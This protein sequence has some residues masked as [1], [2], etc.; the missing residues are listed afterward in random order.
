MA[1]SLDNLPND[2]EELKRLVVEQS[3]QLHH[4]ADQLK[5]QNQLI[6]GLKKELYGRKSEKL[7]EEEKIQVRLFNEVEDGATKEDDVT[8]AKVAS[9]KRRKRGRKPISPDFPRTEVIHDIS[10]E[11]KI[12]A[13][14]HELS[15]IGE[16][17]SE[18]IDIIPMDI[19]VL[20]H[21]RPKYACK[22]C[23]GTATEGIE[24]TV[25]I[26]KIPEQML[27]KS[28]SSPGLLAH[29]LT[30]KFCDALPFYRQEKIFKRFGLELPRSTM[31]NMAIG[32]YERLDRYLDQMFKELLSGPVLFIDETPVQVLKEPGKKNTSKSYM[33]VLR[34][35]DPKKPVVWY[36]Y[37]PTRSAAFLLNLLKGYQGAV[38]TDGYESYSKVLAEL[39][40]PHAGCWVHARRKFKNAFDQTKKAAGE[41]K[42]T[43][44]DAAHALAV[45]S[46]LY[47]LD[48]VISWVKNT[49]KKKARRQN[50]I[51]PLLTEFFD[52]LQQQAAT[53]TPRSLLGEAIHYTIKQW[54]KLVTFLEYPDVPLDNNPVENSIRPFVLGR[55]N[56]LFS[57]SPRGADASAAIY[58]IIETAK[59]NGHEPYWYLRF[60]FMEY[61]KI[62]SEK[63]INSLLPQNQNYAELYKR[64][65]LGA[66]G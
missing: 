28:L 62:Q 8:T 27:P 18:Q 11:D 16:E 43:Q 32:V 7:T 34:S 13:C 60:L 47:E 45:I 23:E 5:R 54:P 41:N 3:Q 26:A 66:V 46:K 17:T 33:W 65:R 4:Q 9:H 39:K 14:G 22:K 49:A 57:G 12:C 19:K 1:N 58:S 38:L 59:A 20:R 40:I 31:C 30:A 24:P 42:A 52:W 2:I 63:E 61:P 64:L 48:K 36:T 10:E 56:W 50:E 35:G 15:R 37:Q 44:T 21:V 25:K 6:D 29:T 51:Q 53:T 55:K